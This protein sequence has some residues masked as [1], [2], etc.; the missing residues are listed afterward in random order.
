MRASLADAEMMVHPALEETFGM[1]VLEAMAAGVVTVA[2]ARSGNMPR[3]L[4]Y[5]RCGRLCD[6]SDPGEIA[7]AVLDVL[8]DRSFASGLATAARMRALQEYSESAVLPQYVDY[9]ADVAALA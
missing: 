9:Y 1:T 3:L 4:D 6:V 8:D 7:R 5:G 2:G